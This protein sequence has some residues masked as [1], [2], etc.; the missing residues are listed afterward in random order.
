MIRRW[1]ESERD[2]VER[3]NAEPWLQLA[4]AEVALAEH[5]PDS[6]IT[7]FGRA[8]TLPDGPSSACSA[9]LFI[10]LARAYDAAG[11]ADSTIAALSRALGI[12]RT[13]KPG[14]FSPYVGPFEKRLGELW[15][16]KGDRKRA[17]E[18]Y[19]R[20]VSLWKDA[21]PELQPMVA[22]VRQRMTRLSD[23]ERR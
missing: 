17:Y 19:A 1:Q 18:H 6:A 21:E 5:R 14:I 15:E 10:N 13:G 16:Q 4:L 7:A 8:D 12:M 22:D 20:F 2:S 9:C 11:N 3:R 23:S